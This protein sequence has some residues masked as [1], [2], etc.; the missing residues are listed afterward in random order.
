M[1]NDLIKNLS[2]AIVNS[3]KEKTERLEKAYNCT[4]I[5]NSISLELK[6]EIDSK[7]QF[8]NKTKPSFITIKQSIES[9]NAELDKLKSGTFSKLRHGSKIEELEN[10]ISLSNISL[11]LKIK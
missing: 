4:Y 2:N 3:V 10:E 9:L 1:E 6:N 5:S 7:I 8:Y 11:Y